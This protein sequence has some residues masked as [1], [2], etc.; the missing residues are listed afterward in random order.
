MIFGNVNAYARHNGQGD[1]KRDSTC[2]RGPTLQDT[3]SKSEGLHR[4]RFRQ[5]FGLQSD[6]LR[7][8]SR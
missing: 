7:Q 4:L 8:R 2:S 6:K 3:N 1:N 5:R